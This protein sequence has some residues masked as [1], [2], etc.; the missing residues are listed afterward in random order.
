[1]A[2]RVCKSPAQLEGGKASRGS[3]HL[4]LIMQSSVLTRINGL[5]LLQPFFPQ[6]AWF[7]KRLA[8]LN[9]F[10]SAVVLPSVMRAIVQ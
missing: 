7:K 1:M 4:G 5:R 6:K 9:K 10:I 8:L 2:S 3:L